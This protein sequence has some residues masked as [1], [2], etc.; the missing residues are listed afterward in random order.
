V[1]SL[2]V[3]RRR[4]QEAVAKLGEALATGEVK[5]SP[6]ELQALAAVCDAN[7]LPIEAARVRRWMAT[8]EE[9]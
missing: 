3:D 1:T 2:T 8:K 6:G 9:P 4:L 7:R 5:P